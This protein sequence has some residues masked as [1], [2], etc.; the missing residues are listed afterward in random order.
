MENVFTLLS[1]PPR[2]WTSAFTSQPCALRPCFH[3]K[4][5]ARHHFAV[6]EPHHGPRCDRGELTNL[7]VA[8]AIII[9]I[10]FLWVF[11]CSWPR[12]FYLFLAATRRDRC[13][14]CIAAA[15]PGDALPWTTTRKTS[16]RERARENPRMLLGDKKFLHT[17]TDTIA[18]VNGKKREK[19]TK[20]NEQRETSRVRIAAGSQLE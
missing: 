20:R 1:T 13:A 15:M 18:T 19:S 10:S 14:R 9:C 3:R 11:Y 5:A 2:G 6:E 4:Y 16:E 17:W 7:D 8:N 12:L